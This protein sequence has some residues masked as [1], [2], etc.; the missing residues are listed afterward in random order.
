MNSLR[1]FGRA[2]TDASFYA[3]AQNA[4]GDE[5]EDWRLRLTA[6][7]DFTALMKR[8]THLSDITVELAVR[9]QQRWSNVA[10]QDHSRLYFVPTF[11]IATNF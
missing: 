6:G 9:Y 10:G 11:R 3:N 5:R 2:S 8:L 4:A 1:L 7:V